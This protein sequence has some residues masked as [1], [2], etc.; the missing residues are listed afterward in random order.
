MGCSS[1]NEE[2][3][4]KKKKNKKKKIYTKPPEIIEENNDTSNKSIY[5]IIS[6]KTKDEIN[7]KMTK[8]EKYTKKVIYQKIFEDSKDH[9]YNEIKEYE[10]NIL[11]NLFLQNYYNKYISQIYSEQKYLKIDLNRNEL[12]NIVNNGEIIHIL[13]ELII[14]HIEKIKKEEGMYK[15]KN[16]SIF[17]VGRKG[18]GKTTLIDYILKNKK[19]NSDNNFEKNKCNFQVITSKKCPYLR[20]IEFKGIGFGENNPETIKKEA[21]EYIKKQEDNNNYNNIVHCIWYCISGT[22]FE[23][24]EIVLL[25]KLKEVYNDNNIPIIVI[26]T[27]SID[28]VMA[29]QMLDYIKKLNIGVSTIKVMAKDDEDNDGQVIYSFGRDRLLNLTLKKCTQAL[30]GKM[31][32][33]MTNA[34]MNYIKE[35][36]HDKNT[37]NRKEIFKKNLDEFIDKYEQILSENNFKNYLIDILMTG[38]LYLLDAYKD[39][40]RIDKLNYT[41][42]NIKGSNMFSPIIQKYK[43]YYIKIINDSAKDT[44][45]EY[46]KDFLINQTKIEIKNGNVKKKNKRALRDIENSNDL[47]FKKNFYY[48]FQKVII[49]NFI[50]D[51]NDNYYSHLQNKIEDNIRELFY[52]DKA[53]K[54]YLSYC[55]LMKLKQFS[56][57]KNIDLEI[58]PHKFQFRD[59]PYKEEN[60][61]FNQIESIIDNSKQSY[62]IF[63]IEKDSEDNLN[64]LLKEDQKNINYKQYLYANCYSLKNGESLNNFMKQIDFQIEDEFF[65]EKINDKVYTSLMEKIKDNLENYFSLKIDNLI[66]DI[67]EK[68]DLNPNIKKTIKHKKGPN[69]KKK[70]LDSAPPANI[71]DENNIDFLSIENPLI[72]ILLREKKDFF[73]NSIKNEIEKL[74]SED[75]FSI[76]Y[77][78][79]IIVGKSG[80]GKSTLINAI[81]QENL[82]KT[83]APEIQTTKTDKYG[84]NTKSPYFQMIDTRGIEL[85]NKYGPETII[86]NTLNS[87]KEHNFN[88]ENN[89]GNVNNLIQGIWYCLTGSSIEDKEIEIINKLSEEF[90][91]EI[92][93]IIVYTRMIGKSNF[94]KMK[95]QI[96]K[97]I[98]DAILIPI[99]AETVI[100]NDEDNNNIIKSF[101]LEDLKN[102]TLELAKK[103][104]RNIFSLLKNKVYEYIKEKFYS[105]NNIFEEETKSLIVDSFIND[106]KEVKSE[107]DFFDYIIKLLAI[108]FRKDDKPENKINKL[109][110]NE[111][112]EMDIIFNDIKTTIQDSKIYIKEN[113]DSI[114]EIKSMNFLNAQAIIE[115]VMNKS[116]ST[117]SK[118]DKEQFKKIINSF[119]YDNF[120]YISQKFIIYYF[121][122]SQIIPF[123][124]RIKE[125]SNKIIDDLIQ[126]ESE[127]FFKNLY[128]KKFEDFEIRFYNNINTVYSQDNN[129]ISLYKGRDNNKRD[130]INKEKNIGKDADYSKDG[131][132]EVDDED[133]EYDD[134]DNEEDD[135]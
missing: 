24:S 83:G 84:P 36:I 45:T 3:K 77:L 98:K 53:I 26:N 104:N 105:E 1:C 52:Q 15:I 91:G 110:I 34:I 86:K 129:T 41:L 28:S 102:K 90:K 12:Y 13:K 92:P 55:F 19:Y 93:L 64:N 73:I 65:S 68:F 103:S 108:N 128:T 25:K 40:N 20:L 35:K 63:Q 79:V 75:N 49:K 81:L 10:L 135:D 118:K 133:N 17:V 131:D 78:T 16:L 43:D 4:N 21:I 54:D 62:L 42:N 89:S 126:N 51:N 61:E 101:G 111:L 112:K 31:I 27:K 47:F 116:I 14:E 29:N 134:E 109:S 94:N 60:F 99:L 82:A 46:A 23:E 69:R 124:K 6:Q 123:S 38:I 37:N 70:V 59:L 33:I 5:T 56:E 117:Q 107:N 85:N 9:I 66:K 130:E 119:L 11:K 114:L 67:R 113:I 71:N 39:A 121:I 74:K 132:N 122:F 76:N 57:D 95:E 88:E 2:K 80:V 96:N 58:E 100:N 97:K 125:L 22:R 8:L 30:K 50:L 44:I 18:V 106:F 87:I 120:N 72:E 7:N 32:D 115:K 48:I 127:K